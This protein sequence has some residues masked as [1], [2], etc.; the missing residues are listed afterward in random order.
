VGR[1][2]EAAAVLERNLEPG[3]GRGRIACCLMLAMVHHHLGNAEA[4]QEWLKEATQPMDAAGKDPPPGV[5]CS[6]WQ[7]CLLW[8]KEAESLVGQK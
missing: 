3:P 7:T 1:H 5:G 8:R 2:A 4:A 6:E